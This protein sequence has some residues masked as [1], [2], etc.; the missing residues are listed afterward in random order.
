[1]LLK[2]KD[3]HFGHPAKEM[4]PGE[5]LMFPDL[6]DSRQSIIPGSPCISEEQLLSVGDINTSENEEE[7]L[8]QEGP[9]QNGLSEP[10]VVL[11]PDRSKTRPE[12]QPRN[13][14]VKSTPQARGSKKLTTIANPER[15]QAEEKPYKCIDCGKG[16]KGHSALSTHLQI[17][18]GAKPFEC[19]KCEKSFNRKANLMVHERIH[20]GERPYQCKE[21][22]KS[23]GCSSNLI[24]HRKTHLKK[25]PYTCV[26]CTK[27][28]ATSAALIQHQRVHVEGKLFQ[29]TKCTKSFRLSS[30]FIKHQKVHAKDSP[31]EH[32]TE[33]AF[34]EKKPSG[35]A[36]KVALDQ[37]KLLLEELRRMRE[38]VDM[39]LLNQQSQL[40]VLQ[41]IQKQL[42]ILLPGNDL[43]NSNVYSLGLL[44]GQQ[45]AAMASLS[46]PQL[47]NPSS[48]L[49]RSARPLS[50]QSSTSE[51]FTPVL[52]PLSQFSLTRPAA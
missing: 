10:C 29:C 9:E 36:E 15:P 34:Q 11:S 12:R 43:I 46:C 32:T 33:L 49:P 38:N 1:M 26:T 48:L 24:A 45:A 28:F 50:S 22:E 27:S 41:E 40:Q 37:S 42:S 2:W 18:T 35:G 23:F 3:S 7:K 44:L 16:F 47:L 20:T 14:G 4:D 17:H 6:Q 8:S 51:V 39:L 25:K 13:R 21:C 31:R 52:P 19:T 5:D 30:N